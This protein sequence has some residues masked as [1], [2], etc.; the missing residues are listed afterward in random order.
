MVY[1]TVQDALVAA[2]KRS[3]GKNDF[4]EEDQSFY[5]PLALYIDDLNT[6]PFLNKDGK[7][8][9][10][11]KEMCFK[12]LVRQLS[13]RLEVINAL[14]KYP[15]IADVPLPKII[16]IG[17]P[18]RSGSTLLHN[19]LYHAHKNAR[20]L[21]KWE[22]LIVS[23][24][25]AIDENKT[26]ENIKKISKIMNKTRKTNPEISSMH[27]VDANDPEESAFFLIDPIAV[28]GQAPALILPKW[29]EY[30][31]QSKN[32]FTPF[33][34]LK[35]VIQMLC[36]KNPPSNDAYLVLKCPMSTAHISMFHGVFPDAKVVMLHRDPFRV[37]D[38]GYHLVK[39]LLHQ[40]NAS[41]NSQHII[42]YMKTHLTLT[43][44][45]MIEFAKKHQQDVIHVHYNELLDD[46]VGVV[47]AILKKTGITINQNLGSRINHFIKSQR[48]GKR[49]AAPRKY[50]SSEHKQNPTAIHHHMQ[51]YI[52]Y[53]KVPEEIK[54]R[55]D[56]TDTNV[57]SKI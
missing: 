35:K 49:S 40:L 55:V 13:Y 50:S 1:F 52:E 10:I 9:T 54:R 24:L 6:S 47:N 39:L 29:N 4:D 31:S 42:N 25:D 46:P 41:Q 19:L 5:I 18:I 34:N 27:F 32:Y 21:L 28:A 15:Q 2:T 17:S 43:G 23:P 26:N 36:W 14:K 7:E 11:T 45:A 57:I 51:R 8:K 48:A 16:M 56:V 38:S 30:V 33:V 3:G 20:A 44:D 53:F 12:L 22:S 37:F